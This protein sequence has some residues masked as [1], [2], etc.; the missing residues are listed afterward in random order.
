MAK[1]KRTSKNSTSKNNVESLSVDELRVKLN[2]KEKK[3]GQSE[4]KEIVKEFH[5]TGKNSKALE[6]IDNEQTD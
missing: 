1:A 4:Q 3:D 6:R 5:E 2:E